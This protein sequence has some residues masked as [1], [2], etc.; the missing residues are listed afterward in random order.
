MHSSVEAVVLMELLEIVQLPVFFT[1]VTPGPPRFASSSKRH[2]DHIC[3]FFGSRLGC[4]HPLV[5]PPVRIHFFFEV[6][7]C[8][9]FLGEE[10]NVKSVFESVIREE[11]LEISFFCVSYESLTLRPTSRPRETVTRRNECARLVETRSGELV[12]TELD[13]VRA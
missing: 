11:S 9:P 4:P 13:V 12:S 7:E 2:G 6:F 10:C 5:R 3:V 1:G 8:S